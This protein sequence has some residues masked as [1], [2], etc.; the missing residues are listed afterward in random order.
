[1]CLMAVQKDG[2]ACDGDVGDNHRE[3]KRLPSGGT[4]DAVAKKVNDGI[5]KFAQ[6]KGYSSVNQSK[7]AYLH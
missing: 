2:Y 7:I 5:N 4:T 1:M 3:P 6:N